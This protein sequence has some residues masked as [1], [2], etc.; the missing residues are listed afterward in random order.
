MTGLEVIVLEEALKVSTFRQRFSD[1]VDDSGKNTIEL[2]KELHV[3]NQT[4]SAW[5]NGSRSPKEPTIIAIAEHFGVNVE[6]LMGFDVEKEA[7]DRGGYKL[8][9]FF[10][11][12]QKM[13][14]FMQAMP[15]EDYK[16][17]IDILRRAEQKLKEKGEL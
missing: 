4:I 13:V 1:L 9:S 16:E 17:F 8:P 10:S 11:D 15:F 7:P 6:W 5:K 3:S 2:G 12:R 14:K